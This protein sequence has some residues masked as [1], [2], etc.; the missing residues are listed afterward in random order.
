M[1]IR[2]FDKTATA[3]TSQGIGVLNPK[4]CEVREELNGEYELEMEIP[5][6][7]LHYADLALQKI[8]VCK[9]NPYE[10][11]EPFRIYQISRPIGGIVTVNAAHLSY[12]LSRY[13]D[14]PF[15]A[16]TIAS[17][18]SK[19]KSESV[20]ACPFSF[21]TDVT[22]ATVDFEITTP[23]SIRSLL[24]GAEDSV[25]T[26]YGGD[27]KF[28]GYTCY[29]YA[30]RGTNRGVNIRYGTNMT[31]LQQEENCA[32]V[33]S[34]LYPFWKDA[35]G[36][37]VEVTGRTISINANGNG[38]LVYDMSSYFDTQPTAQ[39]LADAAANYIL[40]ANLAA[41]VVSL[42]VKFA[43]MN[44]AN[45]K[46]LLGDTLGVYFPRLQVSASA[47]VISTTYNAI[48]DRYEDIRVG[49]PKQTFAE[50]VAG[51][52]STSTTGIIG[53]SVIQ[54]AIDKVAAIIT[55]QVGGNI[56]LRDNNTDGKLDALEVLDNM[57]RASAT[58]VFK[59]DNSGSTLGLKYTNGGVNGTFTTIL[60]GKA[61]GGVTGRLDDLYL[62]GNTAT[63]IGKTIT[64]TSALTTISNATATNLCSVSLTKGTWLLVGQLTFP[65]AS[66]D[67]CRLY[68]SISGSS[69]QLTYDAY[70]N[71][72]MIGTAQSQAAVNISR[73]YTVASTATMYLV[74]NQNSGSSK[75]LTASR[76]KLTAICI[77]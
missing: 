17:V 29:L 22:P 55:G 4:R 20:D 46:I 40:T 18:M 50:T 21:N 77:G 75:S 67:N 56:Q 23:R 28:T 54:D 31:D 44:L 3:F 8:I 45:D 12:D 48:L 37:L 69:A 19:L 63:A 59:F 13:A 76:N 39:E 68:A 35:E 30:T 52:S 49:D 61:G 70:V 27:W 36:H 60:E 74:A 5:I 66:A 64:N 47:R 14:K 16:T 9:P 73:V 6:T 65:V 24:A 7:D 10:S 51:L 33:Y 2:L 58:K 72:A 26:L 42:D 1:N 11:A 71:V 57:N 15:S 41:P 43:Q 34:A 25:Q 53:Q 38:T 32:N 62:G